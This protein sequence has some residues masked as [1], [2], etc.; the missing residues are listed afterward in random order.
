MMKKNGYFGGGWTI[1]KS[2]VTN[3]YIRRRYPVLQS[4]A[5]VELVGARSLVQCTVDDASLAVWI[6]VAET[7]SAER[8]VAFIL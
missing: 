4:C 2:N 7:F 5:V 6:T 1:K 8:V 3:F